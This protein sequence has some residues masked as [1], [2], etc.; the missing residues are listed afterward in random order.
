MSV[1]R[2]EA[3]K[4]LG[5]LR[6]MGNDT[7]T[8]YLTQPDPAMLLSEIMSALDSLQDLI[9]GGETLTDNEAMYLS[10]VAQQVALIERLNE[11]ELDAV[12]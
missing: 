5:A 4:V 10:S 2:K 6:S 1:S 9:E 3:G 8:P 11:H 12:G 7:S